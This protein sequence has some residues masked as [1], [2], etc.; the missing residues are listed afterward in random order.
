MLGS[1]GRYINLA[2]AKFHWRQDNRDNG[3]WLEK[4]PVGTDNVSI[5]RYTYGPIEI[6]TSVENPTLRIGSFCSIST[7]VKFLTGNE[8][9]LDLLSTYPFSVKLLGQS[10]PEALSKGGIV[11]GDDVWIGLDALI[12]DGVTIGQGAVVAARAVVTHDVEPY[13]IVGGCPARTIR[14]RF[15]D[16]TISKLLEIDWS[17]V[18][19]EFVQSHRDFFVVEKATPKLAGQMIAELDLA[20]QEERQ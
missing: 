5:G 14:K 1:I 18:N 4:T 20:G 19:A 2:K 15:E 10:A 11:V 16:A 7:G 6:S 13:A 17:R 3:T 8:H 12:L 9:P